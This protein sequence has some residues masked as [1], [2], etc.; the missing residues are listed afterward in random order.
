MLRPL[1]LLPGEALG[2]FALGYTLFSVLN[3][4]RSQRTAYPSAKLAWDDE[5]PST[6]EIHLILTS[7]PLALLFDPLSQRLT[8]IEVTGEAGSWVAYRGK[9]LREVRSEE[10]E[11]VVKT[12]RRVMG[13]TYNSGRESGEGE[14][15]LSYP[16]VAFAVAQRAD[17]GSSLSRIILTP[18]P[19][20]PNV[21]V[22]QAWLHPVLPDSPAVAEGD[23]YLAEIKL[24]SH[25]KPSSVSLHFHSGEGTPTPPVVLSIGR[26]TSEDLMCDL[27]SPVRT[28][29]KEDDRMSIH[30]SR[31]SIDPSLQ[32][33]AYFVSHPHL[34]L[35]F[36]LHPTKHILLKIILHSDLPGEINFGRTSRCRWELVDS[37]GERRSSLDAFSSIA[38]LLVP[39]SNGDET[40]APRLIPGSDGLL[41]VNSGGGSRVG[42]V[43]SNR[44]ASPAS[45]GSKAGRKKGKGRTVEVE[46]SRPSTS[47]TEN[48]I[49]RPMVLDRAADGG[50][51]PVKGKTTEIHGFPGIALEVTGSGDLETVWLF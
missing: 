3:L 31:S 47:T 22:D 33:N 35:T 50:E 46:V 20:P 2:P 15:V 49:E 24:D 21:S 42:S 1:D 7:P 19:T 27:G 43:D 13:P 4:V 29:W 14:E 10:E 38:E 51:G 12:V 16:G 5:A 32:P 17:G 9:S 36:L 26:T 28:F 18:L 6:S 40:T 25:R 8:R 45:T 23:L 41:S 48:E 39:T 44:S 34:G 30:G 11:D 37:M